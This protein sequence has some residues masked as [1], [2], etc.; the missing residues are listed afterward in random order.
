LLVAA[1]SLR[2]GAFAVMWRDAGRLRSP[3]AGWPESAVAGALGV[4][5]SGPRS[6]GG[7]KSAEPWLNARASDPGPD[8][9][10]SGLTLYCKALALAALVL[11]GIAALQLTS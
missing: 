3:N 5:L 9:L 10:R 2:P 11:A 4:R 7:A 1:A 8:D 6:Y